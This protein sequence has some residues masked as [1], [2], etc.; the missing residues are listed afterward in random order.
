MLSTMGAGRYGRMV[1]F[2]IYL[3]LPF[4]TFAG[5]DR[6]IL[7]ISSYNPDTQNT[8]RNI[9]EFIDEYKLLGGESPILIENMNCKSL[10]EALYWKK[11]MRNILNKYRGNEKPRLVVILGQEAWASYLSLNDSQMAD[12]PVLCG[13][14][15]RNAV[16]LPDSN[17]RISDW[18]PQSIDIETYRK[19]GHCLAGFIYSYD[20]PENIRLIRS[21]YPQTRYIALVTD[22]TY[23]GIS[24]QTYVKD[25][26]KQI[27]DLKLILLDG[28]KNNIYTIM[29]QI[30]KLPRET[31]ILLGSWRVDSNDGYYLGNA[32]YTMRTANPLIPTFTPTSTGLG[33]WAIG[34]LVPMYRSIG[35]DLAKQTVDF[36]NKKVSLKEMQPTDMPNQYVF[37]SKKIKEF[38]ISKSDLPPG[39]VLINTDVNFFQQYK[40]EILLGSSSILLSFLILVLLF[41]IRSNRMKDKLLDLQNDN[42]LI[43]NNIDASI[44]FINPDYTIKW[45]NELKMKCS[46]V[47]GPQNC[48]LVKDGKRPYCPN[49][50]IIDA[51]EGGK[52]IEQTRICDNDKYVQIFA[53]P[54]YDNQQKLLGIIYK[55]EDITRQKENELELCKAKEKAEESDRLKS[56]FLANMSHEIRTP[57]NAIVGFS[58]LIETAESNEERNEFIRIINTNNELLLQLVNDMLDIAR[59]EANSIAFSDTEIDLNALLSEV[60]QIYRQK[61]G[62]KLAIQLTEKTAHCVIRSDRNRLMQ[63]ISNLM[64][65][66]V[67]FTEQGSVR[68]GYRHQDDKFV[69]YVS[70]TGCGIPAEQ[71]KEIFNRFVKL[72]SFTQGV[73][74]GLPICEMIIHKMGGKMGVKSE[75]GTGSTFWFALSDDVITTWHYFDK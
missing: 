16:L 7:I 25:E 13:M 20:I 39:Y 32:T 27:P 28:R 67:K 57:L 11:K 53:N 24:L 44:R 47:N 68:F 17:V 29:D 43:L 50:A 48:C 4:K 2:I 30:A 8:T 12:I 22:N 19:Q 46:P 59:I 35:K 42:T 40:Y 54:V 38:K 74:L 34:G 64:N 18:E 15:S 62:D 21:L 41:F 52:K 75:A 3:L 9:S 36:L 33:H 26:M 14:I 60:E 61:A 5:E 69:F 73:G 56:A 63:V 49:C 66:A 1:I 31:V 72:N 55:K 10:P 37:D 65:N 70:D 6:P 51:I 58:S 23:G 45:E 71:E